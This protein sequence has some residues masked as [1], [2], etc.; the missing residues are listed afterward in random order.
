MNLNLIVDSD[1]HSYLSAMAYPYTRS[2][3]RSEVPDSDVEPSDTAPSTATSPLPPSIFVGP[4][5]EAVEGSESVSTKSAGP[6]SVPTLSF[7]VGGPPSSGSHGILE[8]AGRSLVGVSALRYPSGLAH[9]PDSS[10]IAC[11][12]ILAARCRLA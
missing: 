1:L 9:P 6:V 2:R 5:V 12:P 8:S 10:I 3:A 7:P 4:N 11:R